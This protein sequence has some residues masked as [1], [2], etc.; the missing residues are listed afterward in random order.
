M[1]EC[2]TPIEN[3][4][5]LILSY[6]ILSY[7][8]LSYL[9]LSYLILSYLYLILS[10]LIKVYFTHFSRPHCAITYDGLQYKYHNHDHE[11]GG[12]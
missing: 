9:I 6:L 3:K 2:P 12:S 1:V 10:Y 4:I 8:I 5:Y 11:G 7:L